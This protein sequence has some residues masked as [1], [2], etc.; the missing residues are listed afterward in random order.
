MLNPVRLLIVEDSENDAA[1]LL[2]LMRQA[3]TRC[4][5]NEWNLASYG[6]GSR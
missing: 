2:L 6:T 5:P 3:D 4:N 1:L